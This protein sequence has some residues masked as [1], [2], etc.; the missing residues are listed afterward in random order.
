MVV[1]P[2]I[3]ATLSC[4]RPVVADR[5]AKLVVV[6]PAIWVL[7]NDWA[8]VVLKAVIDVE[9]RV[10]VV[11]ADLHSDQEG[12]LLSEGSRQQD[13]WGINL[14]P[15]LSEGEWIEYDSMI[16][17]R[18]SFGNRSRNVDDPSLRERI[19]ALVRILVE[20]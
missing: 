16:N 10:M 3:A 4:G 17:L 7:V 9:R 13:L 18:P 2:A 11:D 14:Y 6:M 12:H 5:A 20:R 15:E 1:R 19:A 8:C